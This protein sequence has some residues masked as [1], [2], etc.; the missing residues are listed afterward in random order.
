MTVQKAAAWGVHFYTATG[1]V[2][3]VF[4]LLLAAEG[5]VRVAFALLLLTMVIDAT[6]GLLARRVRVSEVLPYFNGAE[7]DNVIDVFTYVWIPVF[8]MGHQGLLP[9][10]VW[11]VPPVLAAM[12]AY[13]QVNMKTP[14]S[15]F[16]G[17][18]SY[19]NIVALYLFWLRPPPVVAV[20]MVTL[21]ALLT[22]IPTRYLY[23]SKNQTLWKT[24]WSLGAVWI[25]L[26]VFLL[27]QEQPNRAL[28]LL[29]L[30]YP[31][32]YLIASFYVDWKLRRQP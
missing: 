27:A 28:V 20:L 32:Y 11:L 9:H 17:F 23:P 7:M 10:P 16:L 13:G 15:Y 5:Q 12:Y 30:F 25:A 14:D 19:W 29:S 26:V 2:I 18:P 4:A 21:P 3:G 8:I 1:G 31:L 22:F 6:D 24:S